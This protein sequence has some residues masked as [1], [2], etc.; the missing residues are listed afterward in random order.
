MDHNACMSEM[1]KAKSNLLSDKSIVSVGWGDSSKVDAK[2]IS[3]ELPPKEE[4][5]STAP[6]ACFS[7]V[8]AVPNVVPGAEGKID[9]LRLVTVKSG[10]A[11]EKAGMKVMDI[12][13]SVNGQAI[14][15]PDAIINLFKT[16]ANAVSVRR[17]DGAPISITLQCP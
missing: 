7:E 14:S 12:I 9:G 4:K 3:D 15:K 17:G 5:S 8:Q 16:G 2:A 11:W 6:P 10:G 13:A 1:R